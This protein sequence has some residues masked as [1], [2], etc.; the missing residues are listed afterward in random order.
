MNT[1]VI[2]ELTLPHTDP[3]ARL[4]HLN[5]PQVLSFVG[6]TFGLTWLLDLYIFLSG[7]MKAP[8]LSYQL[9]LQMLLPAFTAIFLGTFIFKQSPLYFRVNRS[10]SRWFTSFFMLMTLIFML[11][12]PVVT[13]LPGMAGILA[14]IL[15]W[16]PV[17]GLGV[18][19][20]VR[21]AGGK[22]VFKSVGMAGGKWKVWL[23]MGAGLITFFVLLTVLNAVFNLAAWPNP[24]LAY[25]GL[26][27]PGRSVL[28]IWLFYLLNLSIGLLT[29]PFFGLIATFGEEYGWRGYLQTELVKLGRVKGVLILGTIW[30]FWHA[31]LILMGY[32]YPGQP[33][34]G[35]FGMLVFCILVSFILAYAVFRSKGLWTAVYLHALLNYTATLL[36]VPLFRTANTVFSFSLGA[37]AFI[38][39]AL[40]VLLILRDPLWKEIS[41]ETD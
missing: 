3:Q 14:V 6:L 10:V 20:V 16:L 36:L 31:P 22:K 27:V 37:Y 32:N 19:I 30:G 17:L 15:S 24:L 9:E 41:N 40:I 33:V 28:A 4:N 29:G 34:L 35:L 38:P 26:A 5:W 11:A 25:P 8:Y 12:I 1:I 18:V 39:L 21:I 7:G 13:I 23:V 2:N